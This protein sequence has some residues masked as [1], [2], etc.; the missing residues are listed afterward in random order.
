[1]ACKQLL[2]T[3]LWAGPCLSVTGGRLRSASSI[4]YWL[5]S[6]RSAIRRVSGTCVS[7]CHS[8][9][10]GIAAALIC[11]R[12]LTP[13]LCQ[14]TKLKQLTRYFRQANQTHFRYSY[15]YWP[16]CCRLLDNQ[17]KKKPTHTKT[18]LWV[19]F[20]AVLRHF[21]NNQSSFDYISLLFISVQTNDEIPPSVLFSAQ[22]QQYVWASFKNPP[23]ISQN[24]KTP[25]QFVRK[26]SERWNGQ[27]SL[28]AIT[29]SQVVIRKH[30]K[31]SHK[32]QYQQQQQKIPHYFWNLFQKVTLIHF[33]LF[34]FSREFH[35]R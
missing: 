21:V 14:R 19:W 26:T 22:L 32:L 1:M 9:K 13:G 31:A 7:S 3:S 10:L 2:W 12:Q 24:V 25:K 29:L 17:E 20:W 5:K 33:K 30:S 15:R 35:K 18:E 27:I 6:Q 4:F 8:D 11:P 34:S 23:H 16:Y 28:S